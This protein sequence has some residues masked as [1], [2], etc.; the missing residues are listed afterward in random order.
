MPKQ[1]GNEIGTHL[2]GGGD[3]RQE[4]MPANVESS[5]P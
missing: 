1:A 4:Y 2:E 3:L 5:W